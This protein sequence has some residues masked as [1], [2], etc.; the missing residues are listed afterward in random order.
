M[1]R[2]AFCLL[3][4]VSVWSVAVAADAPRMP[5]G[6]ADYSGWVGHK[7]GATATHDIETSSDPTVK[8]REVY[9]LKTVEHGKL[10]LQRTESSHRMNDSTSTSTLTPPK[11]EPKPNPDSTLEQGDE[12]VTIADKTYKCHFF[13]LTTKREAT[14]RVWTIWT[15]PE[16][17]GGVVKQTT[18]TT[19]SDKTVSTVTDTLIE[20]KAGE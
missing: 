13:K 20:F 2:T 14:T 1:I 19:N 10:T 12:D 7:V 17:P 11:E 15:N 8:T 9:T 4:L 16:I 6:V 5:S 18:V 3:A